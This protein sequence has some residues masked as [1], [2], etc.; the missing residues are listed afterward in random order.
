MV[1]AIILFITIIVV[2]VSVFVIHGFEKSIN[3]ITFDGLKLG[4]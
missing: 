2:V 4:L 3:L 1:V